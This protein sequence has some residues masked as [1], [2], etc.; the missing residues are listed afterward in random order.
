MLKEN[1][2]KIEWD[3][4][5]SN[6]N[7]IDL[8]KANLDKINWKLLSGNPNAIELLKENLIEQLDKELKDLLE[9]PQY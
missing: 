6:P 5:A 1:P 2:D 9:S 7:A 3:Y 8:L 4:L